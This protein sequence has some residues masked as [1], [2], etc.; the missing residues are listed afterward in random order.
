MA[1]T[2]EGSEPKGEKVG[3]CGGGGGHECECVAVRN[4]QRVTGRVLRGSNTRA[5]RHNTMIGLTGMPKGDKINVGTINI[6]GLKKRNT[7]PL[8]GHW[9]SIHPT[10]PTI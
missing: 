8:K 4:D 9:S 5:A 10:T 2:R 3:G 1:I 7:S 6:P